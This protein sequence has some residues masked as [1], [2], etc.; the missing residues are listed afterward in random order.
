MGHAFQAET[1]IVDE[2]QTQQ[3]ENGGPPTADIPMHEESST[4][5]QYKFVKLNDRE[6]SEMRLLN[7]E[8]PEIIQISGDQKHAS[9]HAQYTEKIQRI[10]LDKPVT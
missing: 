3:G 7:A 2:N 8:D 1:A 4:R 9:E 10:V 5:D 6:Q